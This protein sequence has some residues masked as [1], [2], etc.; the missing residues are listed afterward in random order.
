MTWVPVESSDVVAIGWEANPA[1]AEVGLG[2]LGVN[3]LRSG[4]Y[5]Y[6]DV[7]QE[8][9]QEFLAAPSKGKFA[10]FVLKRSNYAYEKF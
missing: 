7:P 1:E 6:F 3:F 10:N 4:T 8:F 5:M 9:F 2:T